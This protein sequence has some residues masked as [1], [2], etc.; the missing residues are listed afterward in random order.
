MSKNNY[1]EY[2]IKYMTRPEAKQKLKDYKL[3]ILPIGS[4]EQHGPHLPMGTDTF[5]AEH[6][7]VKLAE[8]LQAVVFPAIPVGY[9]WVWRNI[10]G[11]MMI[12]VDTLKSMLKDIIKNF[13]RNNLER[14][15]I[16]N[17]H[18]AN[19]S[20]IKYAIREL[21]DTVETE[22][23][24]FT[25]PGLK[26]ASKYSESPKWHNMVHA[27]EMETS[28]LLA[29]R[30]DLCDM[31]KAVKEYPDDELAYHY[32]YSNLPMGALSDSGVYGN[33]TKATKEKGEV[34]LKEIIDF[35]EEIVTKINK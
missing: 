14:L 11:N 35:M 28:W 19:D 29:V 15:V 32:H 33:A 17:G 22:L 26:R 18:G 31:D 2:E 12:S 34:M 4:T 1:S 7:A 10:P 5:L 30:P 20:S 24:Y 8:R 6:M 23:I 3:G 16:I 27:C 9:S 13:D 25:Y 21:A